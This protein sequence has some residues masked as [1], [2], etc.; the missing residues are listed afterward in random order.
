MAAQ[1]WVGNFF[2]DL[3][4]NQ[5][6]Q[7]REYQTIPPKALAV[8]TCLAKNANKV[9]SH[10][11]LLSQV[12]PD[13]I[14]TPNTLQRSIAQLRKALSEDSQY[15]SYI[16]T[17]AK[18]GYS[19]EVEVR[20]QENAE[21][22]SLLEPAPVA[23]SDVDTE[24]FSTND[25]DLS[26]QLTQQIAPN[27]QITSEVQPY[28]TSETNNVSSGKYNSHFLNVT[29]VI[30]LLALVSLASSN[31]LSPSQSLNLSSGKLH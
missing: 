18:Q 6:S 24:E 19:L 28:S 15:Q 1:Y 2:I 31:L 9:V 16:K 14:V 3:T 17:H 11:E 5:I 13:T 7:K 8:L 30:V 10:E 20:W 29:L 26:P 12:W 4:R 22:E 27:E 21:V 23:D 25:A